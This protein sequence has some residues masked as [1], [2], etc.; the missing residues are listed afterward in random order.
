MELNS[1]YALCCFT[2]S[3]STKTMRECHKLLWVWSSQETTVPR[4]K[5]K[6]NQLHGTCNQKVKISN[7]EVCQ[8][9]IC[10]IQVEK[11]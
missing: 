11:P 2:H 8:C 5:K 7:S 3:T 4:L 6:I 9:V 1:C 10:S